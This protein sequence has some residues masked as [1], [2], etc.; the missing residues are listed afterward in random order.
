[1]KKIQ[2]VKPPNL[3]GDG[4]TGPLSH[5]P[6]RAT[7]HKCSNRKC[8]RQAVRQIVMFCEEVASAQRTSRNAA[9]AR[10]YWRIFHA[11]L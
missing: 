5:L 1:V 11:L 9:S 6:Q 4:A 2:V 8:T 10:S 3:R 7:R